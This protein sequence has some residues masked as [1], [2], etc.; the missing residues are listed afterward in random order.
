VAFVD[1]LDDDGMSEIFSRLSALEN[2]TPLSNSSVNR[3]RV[4]MY[5]GSELLIQ[6]GN[7]TV[8]GAASIIGQLIGSGLLKWTGNVLFEGPVVTDGPST[9]NG[10]TETN[11]DT[12]MNGD[13]IVGTGAIKVGNMTLTKLAGVGTIY[14][15]V[16]IQIVAPLTGISGNLG[17]SGNSTVDGA[18]SFLMDHPVKPGWNIQ[19]GCTESPV[20]STE[21]WGRD[22]FDD[23][24]ECVVELPDY[25]EALNK[26]RN[27]ATMVFA[28]GRPFMV[29][30]D[31][32]ADGR[33]VAYG[34]PGR[35]F[36]WLVK[37]ERFGGDFETEWPK[38]A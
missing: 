21:Y 37:A 30:S 10:D 13:L 27:R 1:N 36:R 33:F 2:A 9:N 14:S 8:A 31:D 38:A 19:H 5:G 22:T 18:K 34:E 29:G 23:S 7:L 3:G 12:V 25:F 32:I 26:E 11:G 28:V 16:G 4:R 15:T 24:G 17:V 20:S 35:E 6:D